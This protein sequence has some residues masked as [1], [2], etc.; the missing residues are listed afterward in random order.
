M[1]RGK[2]AGGRQPIASLF[3][4]AAMLGCGDRTEA[5]RS[6][7]SVDGVALAIVYDTSGS[8]AERV[9]DGTGHNSPKYEIATR[10]LGQVVDRLEAFAA[11]PGGPRRLDTGLFV[12]RG[13]GA[14]AA[15]P[16]GPFDAGALR[17]W[18]KHAPP[19]NGT[20]PLGEAVRTATEAVLGS[21][22]KRKHVLVLTD[23]ENTAGPDPTATL[24]RLQ[25]AAAR[26]GTTFSVH[27]VAFDVDAKRF[28]A[29]KDLGAT[30]VGAAD[31]R[32]LD[33]QFEFILERKILLED[34]ETSPPTT[35]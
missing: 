35:H 17:A 22:L 13:M 33:A 19:P 8:M 23:G 2:T 27:F 34:E 29:V 20:T 25:A 1:S 4:L 24:P 3:V 12:F 30:V 32:E 10:A 9:P 5:P 16:F 26:A 7:A 31:E 28:N 21:P 11:A 14:E 6:V 18:I 15:V